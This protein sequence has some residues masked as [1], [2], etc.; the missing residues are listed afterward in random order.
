VVIVLKQVSVIFHLY[1]GDEFYWW[2]KTR[3]PGENHRPVVS[4]RQTL[5]HN[6]SYMIYIIRNP[7][8]KL[9]I[10]A[11]GGGVLSVYFSIDDVHRT[12]FFVM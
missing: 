4:H 3:V 9:G 5:S 8:L 7:I 11:Y 6:N 1:R 12:T 2:R 10:S